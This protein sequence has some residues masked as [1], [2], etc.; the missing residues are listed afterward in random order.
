M[1]ILIG[2]VQRVRIAG[3]FIRRIGR[4]RFDRVGDQAI[5]AERQLADV[6]RRL[7]RRVGA[8]AVAARPGVADVVGRG[9]VDR[10]AHALR[11]RRVDHRRE[12]VVVHV[13]QIGRIARLIERLGH[14]EGDQ[15]TDEERLV[16]AEDRMLGFDHRRVVGVL[17]Q[18]AARQ[19]ADLAEVRAGV[20]AEHAP[21]LRRG[22]GI[23]AEDLRVR[24]RRAHERGIGL[25]RQRDVVGVLTA[26]GE[27]ALVLATLDRLA[28]ESLSCV[29]TFVSRTTVLSRIPGEGR[30]LIPVICHAK[31]E[32]PAFAGAVQSGASVISFPT[33]P[34]AP[35]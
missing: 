9:I 5:V 12:H 21:R 7:D 14:H 4:A 22:G 30:G 35:P 18:P 1:R 27:E 10:G 6:R 8:V 15:V 25:L 34:T 24:V 29:H 23:D 13:D 33:H 28:D 20:D 17:D 11:G 32:A 26:S 16:V 19:A 2:D 31:N 3:Q